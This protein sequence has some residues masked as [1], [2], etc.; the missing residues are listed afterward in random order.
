LE[1]LFCLKIEA[2]DHLSKLD[3][4][5]LKNH[6]LLTNMQQVSAT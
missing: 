1:I 2:V 3:F 5:P 4:C 6:Q